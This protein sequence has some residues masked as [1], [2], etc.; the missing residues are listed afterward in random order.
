MKLEELTE[1][2]NHFGETDPFYVIITRKE[3]RGG[4]WSPKAFF[5]TGVKEVE[6]LM[7]TVRSL[8]VMVQFGRALDFGCGVGRVTQALGTYFHVVYGVDIAPSMIQLAEKYNLHSEKVKYVVNRGADL[9]LFEDG[10][11]DLIYSKITLQHI[12]PLYSFKYIREFLRVLAPNGLL[13]F[14]LP[15]KPTFK[16]YLREKMIALNRRFSRRP[17]FDMFGIEREK[18]KQFLEK[19]RAKIIAIRQDHSTALPWISLCYYV[20]QGDVTR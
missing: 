4:K 13:V 8:G 16:V 6:G 18:V 14:Q 11:F 17:Y 10:S 3:M 9:R 1:K 12:P 20:L 5:E 15:D 7:S 2:W 19:N